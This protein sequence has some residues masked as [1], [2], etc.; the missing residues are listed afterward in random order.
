MSFEASAEDYVDFVTHDIREAMRIGTRI[1]LL[2][3]GKSI[4]LRRLRSFVMRIL[5]K[6]ARS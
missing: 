6:R 3:N 4:G 5:R 1:I 2:A